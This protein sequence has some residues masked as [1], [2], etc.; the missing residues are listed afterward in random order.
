MKDRLVLFTSDRNFL[1]PTLIAAWNLLKQDAVKL[2]ADVAVVTVGMTTHEVS[3]LRKLVSQ[4]EIEILNLGDKDLD[5]QEWTFNKTHVPTSTL[6]RLYTP[7]LIPSHYTNIVYLDGDIQI[8]GDLF[9]LISY[10][11]PPGK[12]LAAP[13][14]FLLGGASVG[15]QS[16]VWR[17]DLSYIR[18]LG[19]ENPEDYF[20]AGVIAA[21]NETWKD[22]CD[23]ALEF[24]KAH[25]ELCRY[26]DQSALNSVCNG[27]TLRLSPA[28]NFSTSFET[29]NGDDYITPRLLHFTGASK[30]WFKDRESPWQSYFAP[31]Y[32]DFVKR[33][34]EIC[35]EFSPSA[36]LGNAEAEVATSKSARSY[37]Y[38]RYVLASRRRKLK[39]FVRRREFLL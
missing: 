11:V 15:W 22:V 9:P 30:P 3:Y 4:F 2:I 13:D 17:D 33:Y 16:S 24:F 14:R 35:K 1:L 38:D 31:L 39:R 26:H 23:S 34:P 19:I 12:I 20:N 5:S 25:S 36:R 29:I 6:A 37:L 10:D 28:Y 32:N 18:C 27:K 7:S 8:V 21:R